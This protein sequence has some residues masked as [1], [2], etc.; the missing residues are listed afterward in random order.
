MKNLIIVKRCLKF[1]QKRCN[2]FF[3]CACNNGE[4]FIGLQGRKEV[5]DTCLQE[6]MKNGTDVKE[7]LIDGVV[8]YLDKYQSE[9]KIFLEKLDNAERDTQ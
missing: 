9:K 2:I 1:L 7:W 3:M 4:A 5:L 8:K 6:L